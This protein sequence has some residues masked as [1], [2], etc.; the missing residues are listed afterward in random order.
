MNKP[1]ISVIVCTYNR[2][3]L[4]PGCLESLAEQST[5]KRLYEVI[6]VDN[7]ST[8]ATQ[9][10]ARSFTAEHPN[11]SV[12][13]ESAQG[14]SHA[15][16]RGWREARG[17]YV[18][19]VD[20]DAVACPDWVEQM[21]SFI[22]R[23]PDAGAFGGPYDAFSTVPVPD[24]FPLEYGRLDLGDEER[25]LKIG[26]EWINGTN[27]VFRRDLLAECGGFNPELGMLGERVSYGEETRLQMDL[28]S[29]GIAVH[30]VPAMK[31]RHQVAAYK[32]KLWW[33]LK[34]SFS[35]G[36]TLATSQDMRRSLFYHCC[37]VGY[38]LLSGLMKFLTMR[39][40]FFKRR[41]LYS[42]SPLSTE[43]GAFWERLSSGRGR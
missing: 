37:L 36:Q 5:D 11:F 9:E 22:L 27:M 42:L 32:L 29:K 7:N 14:L 8:D 35:V 25:P 31:V 24:W 20:D 43:M 13:S 15:R 17:E 16:N 38:A 2:A 39:V 28:A 4:L 1:L 34:S 18:A 30:Y 41:L 21:H 23:R 19:Y 3:D 12:V 10:I 33:L 40:P 26:V 6:V